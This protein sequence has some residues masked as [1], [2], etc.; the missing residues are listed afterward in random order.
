MKIFCKKPALILLII[1]SCYSASA[2]NNFWK[3]ILETKIPLGNKQRKIIPQQYRTLVLDTS[4]LSSFLKTIPKEFSETAKKSNLI[5]T[6]PMPDGSFNRFRLVETSMMEPGLAAKF[7][8]IK[9][10]NGQGI[11]DPY[12]TIKLDWSERGF[13]AM[14]L[15]QIKGSVF[16][17]PYVQETLTNY[18]SYFKKDV[19]QKSPFIENGTIVS[20]EILNKGITAARPQG[21]QCIGGTLRT[22]RLAVACT[23]EYAN[24]VAGATATISQ[25]LAAMVTT[26]N[27]VNGIY[28]SE[29]DIRLVLVTNNDKIVFTDSTKDPFKGNDD[30]NV[31]INESQSNIDNIIGA[32]NYD[33]G[34]TLSTQSGGL[35]EVGVVC[36]NGS[37]ASGVT[38]NSPPSGD[39]FDIDY[40]AH[41]MGHEFGAN[42]T[43]NATTGNCSGNGNST[44]NA[45][46]G[47]GST[48]MGYAGIC[49]ASNDL[50]ANSDPQF[51]AISFNEIT[52]YITNGNGS[53]CAVKTA[54]GNNPP[55]VNAGAS[56]TIPRST[57]FVLTGSAT[58]ADKDALL[59]SWEEIN[60]GGPF[61][62]W[63][64]PK[65]DAPIF[66]S[67]P[68]VTTPVRYFP[69]LSD[70][71][72]NT[73]TIGEILP[74]YSRSLKFRLTARDNHSGGGGVCFGET[75]VTVNGKAGPFKVT[76]PDTAAT[77]NSGTFKIITW[78][79][80]NTNLAPV[81]CTNV[82]IE[83]STD[84]GQTFPVTVLASTPNDGSEEIVVPDNVTTTARIRIKAIDNIFFDISNKNFKIEPFVF[85]GKKDIN[86]TVNLQ[87]QATSE[88]DSLSY[89]IERSING[90]DFV[91]LG[92]INAVNNPDSLSKYLFNDSKP[93][94][95][96]NYYR[97]KQIDKAGRFTY[98]KIVSVAL[99]K[100]GVK[101]TVY[102]NPAINKSSI[103]ILAD[104][105]QVTV[106]LTD[107][108]GREVFLKS[109][110]TLNIGEEIQIPLKGLNRGVYFLT[111]ASDTGTTTN[112]IMVQ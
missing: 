31:L 4:K 37:K 9:T 69:K 52:D 39:P 13:H 48:I 50:Q 76:Q 23:G 103:R 16:I 68:P 67:F 24:A 54:T 33:I 105:K 75:S 5:I 47:S 21:A 49:D 74:T 84:G 95:G 38:G 110:G 20:K 34:H 6:V 2:Q 106:R 27:R 89:E 11:D 1:I 29:L 35:A 83:L 56:Y 7:P 97:I 41:E 51:H 32:D 80:N 55:V 85:T 53:D 107:A 91:S 19:R 101:Y 40:V 42:H 108:L 57:P 90:T 60:V 93:Y 109:F 104:L 10:Y 12:A 86:N 64:A 58:D 44:S 26:I 3:D 15:S 72:N 25:T 28:E 92:K 94:Q 96:V 18:I 43:F 78:S 45:E 99:D 98:T 8:E 17:D 61:G 30:A 71:L 65:G 46:P 22:Y 36:I 77:W 14:I 63:N 102:P 70:I 100:A 62:E 66:R 88:I 73:T 87:W 82:A 79:V 111:L 59:Y 112:K 81:N